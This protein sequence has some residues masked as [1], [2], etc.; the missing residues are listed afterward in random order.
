LLEP[1]RLIY[2][3]D[4]MSMPTPARRR[5]FLFSLRTIFV[6][7]TLLGVSAGI[8]KMTNNLMMGLWVAVGLGFLHDGMKRTPWGAIG[9]GIGGLVGFLLTP[10]VQMHPP[11]GPGP[12]GSIVISLFFTGVGFAVGLAIDKSLGT[13]NTPLDK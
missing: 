8:A 6:V 7:V 3:R 4:V 9:A 11:R 5:R 1:D 2:I 10:Q 12:I 13:R